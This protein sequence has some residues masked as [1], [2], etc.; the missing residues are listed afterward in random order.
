M[1]HS[2]VPHW[3]RHGR[4]TPLDNHADLQILHRMQRLFVRQQPDVQLLEM[5]ASGY[6]QADPVVDELLVSGASFA[7]AI[8]KEQ[9]TAHPVVES[10]RDFYQQYPDWFDLRL[11]RIGARAY[12]RYPL[13]MIWL[14]RNVALMTGYSIPALSLPLVRTGALI[15]DAL[16]RLMR[17]YDYILAVAAEDVL[18]YGGPGWH[19]SVQVREI[20]GRVRQKLLADGWDSAYWGL[21]VNQ[22]DMVATHLQFSLLIMRGYRVLGARLS[23]EET[24]GILHLWRLASY[25]LGVQVDRI[26]ENERDSWRWLYAY[27]ATQRLDFSTGRP[28][29]QALHDLPTE[30]MGEE[31]RI[32]VWTEKV[33]ASVTRLLVGDDIGDGLGLPRSRARYGVMAAPAVLF[34][35]ETAGKVLPPVKQGLYRFAA[36]RQGRINDWMA[37]N[38][39]RWHDLNRASRS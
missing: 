34:S 12:R 2:A 29:A 35:L 23:R 21:P 5:L 4:T 26:P 37:T 14:L 22:T 11:A 20:H 7:T 18:R 19:Q 24:E 8:R 25:W 1:P 28:L 27:V 13:L 9:P 31:N 15:H 10:L 38:T 33:N 36:W 3:Q 6:D 17:T 16:P 39:D 30:V 32:A